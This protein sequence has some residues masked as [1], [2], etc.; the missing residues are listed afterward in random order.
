MADDFRCGDCVHMARC[1][2][3]LG[4]LP[5]NYECDFDP[6]KFSRD[7]L[8]IY[9]IDGTTTEVEHPFEALKQCEEHK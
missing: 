2:F 7:V 1:N 8:T 6:C 4:A 3:L 5:E 9:N